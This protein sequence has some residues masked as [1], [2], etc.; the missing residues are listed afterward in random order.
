MTKQ[1]LTFITNEPGKTLLDSFSSLLPKYTQY[2]DC[3]VGYFYISGF[4]K[5]YKT[6]ESVDKIRILVGL[7]TDKQ[8]SELVNKTKEQLAFEFDSIKKAKAKISENITNEVADAE[9]SSDVE[10][11]ILKFS[12]WINSGKLEVRVYDKSPLHAKLYIMTFKDQYDPGMVITGSSNLTAGGLLGNLEFNVHL[13]DPRDF[14]YARDKFNELWKD[15]VDVSGLYIETI[16]TKTHLNDE[17]TPYQLYL[18]FLYEYF[19][20]DLGLDENLEDDFLPEGYLNLDYQKQAVI[21]AVRILEEYG[22]VFIS[23]VVGLGKTYISARLANQLDGRSL[24]IA[25]P[26]LLDE[27]NPGS[28]PNVFYEFGVRTVKFKSIG[29]L[30][31]ILYEGVDGFKNIFIDESHRFRNESTQT[32]EKLA[33]ICK[34]KRVILVSATPFNNTPGD[35]LSQIKLFQNSRKSTIPNLPDLEGFFSKLNSRLRNLDRKKNYEE[36]MET[37]RDNAKEIRERILKYLMVRRTRTEIR[38]Y[39]EEDL[40]KQGLKFPEVADP[41]AI[42]YEFDQEEDTAFQSTIEFIKTF[43]Y[44]RYAPLLYYKGTLSKQELQSQRNMTLF[45]KMLLIKRFESSLFAF[46]KTLW[47]FITSY[48][49][50]IEE[51]DKGNVYVSKKNANKLFNLLLE[52]NEDEILSMIENEKAEKYEASEFDNRL[53]EDLKYDLDILEGISE[54]WGKIKRDVKFEHFL[55]VMKENPILSKRKVI[56]FTESQETADYLSENLKINLQENVLNFT[57]GSSEEKRA[58][59]IENFDAKSKHP[60]DDYRILVA[61]EV[62]A[63]GVNLHRSNCVVNYDI[64][65]N[66]T[67]L[68]QRI[69]RINRVDTKFSKIYTFNFFPTTQSNDQIKLKEAAEAKIRMFIELLVMMQGF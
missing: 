32:Y 58:E 13:R 22:G 7:G 15:S 35:L 42:Y 20:A 52:G 9:D 56:I 41:E 34:G 43:R 12:E 25:P 24:V 33:E 45:M 1:D 69:G 4:Y 64:P 48:K 31:R 37:V 68:I 55:E 66:P 39:Y 6:L 2:F 14:E 53:R 10:Q 65:W 26:A 23:D 44:S 28:W 18:K 47:R 50:M 30:D 27:G 63:E 67:R 36:Y 11:G 21:N 3:L 19:R 5:I 17:I 59:V 38:K 61:T 8:I 57:G 46:K 16:N 40:S 54:Q 62:L 60:K 51:F 29:Q 49:I